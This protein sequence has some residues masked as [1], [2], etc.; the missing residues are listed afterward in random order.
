M[1]GNLPPPNGDGPRG[2]PQSVEPASI[3]ADPAR[4][5]VSDFYLYFYV[6]FM[7]VLIP[8][9]ILLV[10]HSYCHLLF[11]L[12]LFLILVQN[13]MMDKLNVLELIISYIF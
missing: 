2:Y 6:T 11:H 8:V 1:L 7:I 5:T 10:F 9:F 3:G 13:D 12:I 4:Y